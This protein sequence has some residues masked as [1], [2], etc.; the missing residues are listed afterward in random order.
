MPKIRVYLMDI[1]GYVGGRAPI[2]VPGIEVTENL[3]E[4]EGRVDTEEAYVSLAYG[5]EGEE[6]QGTVVIPFANVAAIVSPHGDPD[7]S[8]V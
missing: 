4:G 3:I 1:P 5:A 2:R 6:E 8:V 7:F